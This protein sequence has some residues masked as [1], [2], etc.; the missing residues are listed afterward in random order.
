[1]PPSS[2][3]SKTNELLNKGEKDRERKL[4]TTLDL[5]LAKEVFCFV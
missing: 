5:E 1:M 3:V 2:A 4:S